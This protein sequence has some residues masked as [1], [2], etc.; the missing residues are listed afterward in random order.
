[1]HSNEIALILIRSALDRLFFFCSVVT[2][3]TH[4]GGMEEMCHSIDSFMQ[5]LKKL[6]KSTLISFLT[7]YDQQPAAQHG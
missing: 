6:L 3:E 2:Y 7:F 1:M 5:Q 4:G